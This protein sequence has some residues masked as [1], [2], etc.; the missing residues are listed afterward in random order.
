MADPPPVAPVPEPRAERLVDSAD[1]VDLFQMHYPRLVRALTLSGATLP[2]AEDVAQEAF[3]RTFRHWRRVRRGANPPGY[4]YLV[5]FRVLRRRGLLSTTPL[6]DA[7]IGALP[8]S[9][10][11]GPEDAAILTVDLERALRSLPPRRRACAVM[12]WCLDLT[13][14]EAADALGIATGTVRK[15]LELA[16]H[17]LRAE[18]G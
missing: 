12:C 3:A 18:L 2:T 9:A 6:D 10:G 7:S 13:P 11:P 16:R 1:F 5:A 8:A 4:L 15:Q 14:S 17:D